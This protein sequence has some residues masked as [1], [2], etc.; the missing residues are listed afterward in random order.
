MNLPFFT[1]FLPIF[2][3]SPIISFSHWRII[4]A[5]ATTRTGVHKIDATFLKDAGIDVSKINPQKIRLFGNGG[6]VY[7]DKNVFLSRLERFNR[8]FAMK[9]MENLKM[10]YEDKNKS[11]YML[12]YAESSHRTTYNAL[13]IL[14]L[15][16]S[17]DKY[18]SIPLLFF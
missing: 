17:S 11:D 14:G 8:K 4:C 2:F 10:M 5:R 9:L 6:G 18:L 13:I 7:H 16:P 3:L 12:F 15:S 1:S